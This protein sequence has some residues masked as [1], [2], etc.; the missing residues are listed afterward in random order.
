MQ[1]IAGLGERRTSTDVVFDYLYEEIG[2]LGLL[3]GDKISEAEIASKFGVSRQPVRD[4]FSRLGNLDMLLIR[5]QKATLVKKFSLKSIE[6]A[7]FVRLSVELEVMRK[8]ALLWDGSALGALKESIVRQKAAFKTKDIDLF[9]T[10]DYEFHK[11]LCQA[12]NSDFVFDVISSNKAQVDRLCVL[13]LTTGDGM[14]E[15]IKDH[16]D[17]LCGLENGDEAGLCATVRK[18][19]SRLDDAIEEIYSEHADY[20]E[21]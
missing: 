17:I 2:S 10:E 14:H 13:S 4:A 11:M 15:L 1:G 19:L 7:R 9:H 16:E 20:F 18:H 6:K 12:A 5:P 8:A 3:P 21:D